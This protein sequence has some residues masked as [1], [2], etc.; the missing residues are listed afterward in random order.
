M[1]ITEGYETNFW[2]L[3][4]CERFALIKN[5]ANNKKFLVPTMIDTQSPHSETLIVGSSFDFDAEHSL[6]GT[7]FNHNDLDFPVLFLDKYDEYQQFDINSYLHFVLSYL[8][9]LN[10][11]ALY[12]DDTILENVLKCAYDNLHI[13]ISYAHPE[14]D[15]TEEELIENVLNGFEY[16]AHAIGYGEVS[17][18][19]R[20]YVQ[21]RG[22][23]EISQ[24]EQQD[25]KLDS[26]F[27]NNDMNF[28][29]SLI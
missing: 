7:I 8:T 12:I 19:L 18:V 1:F 21:H 11:I 13:V 23:L 10:N 2:Q 5:L 14:E 27:N 4:P 6:I 22:L 24:Q 16:F 17:T 28:F 15:V 9:H 25:V 20:L 29:Q 3:V 26:F